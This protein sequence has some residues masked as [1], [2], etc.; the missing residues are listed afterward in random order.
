MFTLFRAFVGLLPLSAGALP[1]PIPFVVQGYLPAIKAHKVY[2]LY[3]RGT[4]DRVDSAVI[5]KGRFQLK[6]LVDASQQAQLRFP[7]PGNSY[8]RLPE[9]DM[10]TV[11]L[12]K[13]TITVTGT[14]RPAQATVTGTP[15]NRESA[16]LETQTAPLLAQLNAYYEA[17][18]HRLTGARADTA[19]DHR[20]D[21][22]KILLLNQLKALYANYIHTHADNPFS[23]Y[24]LAEYEGPQPD[25]DTYNPLFQ[26]LTPSVR[27]SPHGLLVQQQIKRFQPTATGALAPDFS[28]PDPTGKLLKLSELRG[29]Y[30]LLDFWASWCSPCRAENPNIAKAYATYHDKRFTVVSVSM[31]NQ[32]ERAAWLKAIQEDSLTW[33]QVS[34]LRGFKSEIAQQYAVDFIPQNVLLDPQGRVVAK[35]IKGKALSQ[36]LAQLLDHAPGSHDEKK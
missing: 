9:E 18:S 20:A 22:Q 35:N 7:A 25:F 30:V 19:Q 24:V 34:N 1:T 6:G 28:L 26:T 32:S 2:L 10:A 29:Q 31:D 12:E 16:A 3:R 13:G 21:A 33:P 15:L 14:S 11:Y 36:K 23:L 5:T 27:N 17:R 4:T 8:Q